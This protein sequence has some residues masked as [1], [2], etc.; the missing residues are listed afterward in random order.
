M[1]LCLIENQLDESYTKIPQN[2]KS[3]FGWNLSQLGF[4]SNLTINT[5]IQYKCSK[6]IWGYKNLNVEFM[7]DFVQKKK[8]AKPVIKSTSCIKLYNYYLTKYDSFHK[9][10]L[11]YVNL[12]IPK[13]HGL[14]RVAH[15][16]SVHNKYTLHH[17]FK[18]I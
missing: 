8:N 1:T 13:P 4:F 11:Y 3:L 2:L 6:K 18:N 12:H 10:N 5:Q 9:R 14:L 17:F 7:F 15:V 16:T